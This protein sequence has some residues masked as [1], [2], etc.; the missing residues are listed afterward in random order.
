MSSDSEEENY[1]YK[2]DLIKD[3]EEEKFTSD[4]ENGY[5]NFMENI[6]YYLGNRGSILYP[7]VRSSKFGE[8]VYEI[9]HEIINLKK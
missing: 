4:I 6:R 3:V 8:K 7:K 2:I 5:I 1:Q 9:I